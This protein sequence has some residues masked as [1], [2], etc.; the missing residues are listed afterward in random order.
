MKSKKIVYASVSTALSSAVILICAYTPVKFVPLVFA[1]VAYYLAFYKCGWWGALSIVASMLISFFAGGAFQTSFV[2]TL[3][4]FAP[5][6]VLAYAIRKIE[7]TTN[8][9]WI[10]R[11]SIVVPF[12]VLSSIAVL[13][14]MQFITGVS[15]EV[16]VE[17]LGEWVIVVLFALFAVPTDFFFTFAVG[18]MVK[19]LGNLK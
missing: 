8:K 4:L 1:S 6:S 15:L 10:I 11:C 19:I 7:Y 17:K 14:L 9:N 13:M 16:V 12:F 5:Y 3:V 2:L 18:K